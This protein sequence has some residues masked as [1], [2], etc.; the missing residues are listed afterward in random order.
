MRLGKQSDLAR[1]LG[2]SR[3][4][5]SQAFKKHSI[6]PT[7]D[8]LY[9]LD[10]TAWI[11]KE[12]QD[13]LRSSSQ[14]SAQKQL[15]G[16]NN[17]RVRREVVRQLSPVW[18]EAVLQTLRDRVETSFEDEEDFE[19]VIIWKIALSIFWSNFHEICEREFPA[20]LADFEYK[21]P[22][23]L[24]MPIYQEHE[25]EVFFE[26]VLGFKRD[27]LPEDFNLDDIDF[28][29]SSIDLELE[30]NDTSQNN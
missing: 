13:Q 21:K 8:G 1:E 12:K 30:E 10:Y 20:E 27:Q 5:V 24:A 22:D 11:L 4:A 28:D 19:E 6:Q 25:K 3:S 2:I 29:L 17:P 18:E 15:P 26:S 7:V 9:D 16:V 23:L 14:R